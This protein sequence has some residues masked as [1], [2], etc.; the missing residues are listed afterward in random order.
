MRYAIPAIL[1]LALAGCAQPMAPMR[2]PPP[3]MAEAPAAMMAPAH[4][5]QTA[6]GPVLADARGMTLYTFAKDAPGRSNCNG[7]CAH[8]WPPLMAAPGAE[9]AGPWSVVVR[10]DGSR[11]W[12]YRGRPLYTW[13]KDKKP[14]D[15]T[16]EGVG[17]VWHVA[18]P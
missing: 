9:P 6:I 1:V 7:K 5:V 12:A 3:P 16:G 14:G 8:A 13:I 18:R 2:P 10:A 11:M 4:P 17:K 15:T